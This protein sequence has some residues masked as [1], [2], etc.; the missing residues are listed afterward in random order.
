MKRLIYQVY[1]GKRSNLYD[2]CVAAVKNYCRDH[3]IGIDKEKMYLQVKKILSSNYIR[4]NLS[5]NSSNLIDGKGCIR[6]VNK[7]S[8]I[9]K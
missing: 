7:I 3:G 2:H 6:I 5:S 8:E 4:K 1:V 9:I